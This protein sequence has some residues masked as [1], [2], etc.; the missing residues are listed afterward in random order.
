MRLYTEDGINDISRK[1]LLICKKYVSY[2]LKELIN[3]CITSGVYHTVFKN[4]QITPTHKK[5]P[6][7]T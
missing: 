6:F 7:I 4:A 5:A 1:I 3:S 2:Y